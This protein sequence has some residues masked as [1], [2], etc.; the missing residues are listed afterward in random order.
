MKFS[1]QSKADELIGKFDSSLEGTVFSGLISAVLIINDKYTNDGEYFYDTNDEQLQNA[2]NFIYSCGTPQLTNILSSMEDNLGFNYAN[3]IERMMDEL[4]KLSKRLPR[5]MYEDIPTNFSQQ[6][7]GFL[8]F[9]GNAMKIFGAGKAMNAVTGAKW[10]KRAMTKS[11][12]GRTIDNLKKQTKAVI[13][14]EKVTNKLADKISNNLSDM[15]N[16]LAKQTASKAVA[17]N[18]LKEATKVS[19]KPVNNLK[20]TEANISSTINKPAAPKVDVAKVNSTVN[21]PEPPKVQNATNDLNSSTKKDLKQP[22]GSASE[23]EGK[24]AHKEKRLQ[25]IEQIKSHR[26]QVANK[27]IARNNAQIAIENQKRTFGDKAKDAIKDVLGNENNIINKWTIGMTKAG[28]SVKG[29]LGFAAMD[30]LMDKAFGGNKDTTGQVVDNSKK[31][32]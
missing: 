20:V 6:N 16:K 3:K 25:Q 1:R 32:S 15:K 17:Q 18:T 19:A 12:P 29:A 10:F 30:A 7:F 26:N 23:L 28:G 2:S 21:K 9:V 27:T 4:I 14:K 13:Q 31:L 8:G 24:I 22:N 5:E 11:A